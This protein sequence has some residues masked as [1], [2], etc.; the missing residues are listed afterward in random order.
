MK[1][2]DENLMQAMGLIV[3]FSC[4]LIAILVTGYLA[5]G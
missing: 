2:I 4:L 3:V 5:S 1:I